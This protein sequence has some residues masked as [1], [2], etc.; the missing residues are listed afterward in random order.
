MPPPPD[1]IAGP[2]S[3]KLAAA[4]RE[5]RRLEDARR[6][7][8]GGAEAR[9]KGARGQLADAEK[10]LGAALERNRELEDLGVWWPS[11]LSWDTLLSRARRP[12][13]GPAPFSGTCS[14]PVPAALS[15]AQHSFLGHILLSR[16]RRP[17]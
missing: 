14:S 13:C 4:N 5:V 2:F 15:V 16:A 6:E 1:L 8:V 12:L 10:E 11:T 9:L 7:E 3:E 17:L